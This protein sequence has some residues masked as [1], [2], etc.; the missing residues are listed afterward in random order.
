VPDV[1]ETGAMRRGR[2]FEGAALNYLQEERPD[3]TIE[4]PNVF[5]AD[6]EHKLG[7]TPDAYLRVDGR[8]INCQIKTISRPVFER[9]DGKAPLGYQLQVVTENM[10]SEVG[11]GLLAVLVV[12]AHDAFLQTFEVPRHAAAEQ[13][14]MAIA[15]EFWDMVAGGRRPDAD[16]AR[17][18][19]P[20]A[21][22]F[23]HA[24]PDTILDLSGDN[25]LPELLRWRE[26]RK[27]YI[28]RA[29]E[30]VKAADTEIKDK[31]GNAEAAILPG[32]RITW[33]DEFRKAYEVRESTRRV[34]RVKAVEED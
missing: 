24:T 22:L 34:L 17:D 19:E 10:L 5:I 4:R 11:S 26:C 28:A 25:R 13:R 14:I 33:K 1:V 7:A 20:I 27:A 8:L 16:Y 21:A 18:A 15:D 32:W 6:T 12:S 9:W 29:E 3:V 2:H 31:M 23:P 30:R